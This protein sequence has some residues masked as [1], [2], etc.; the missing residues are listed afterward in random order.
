[1]LNHAE[2]FTLWAANPT[3]D[4][5][6]VTVNENGETVTSFCAAGS[7]S[8]NTVT[9]P[10]DSTDEASESYG[11]STGV[12]AGIAVACTVV[13]CVI[14]AGLAYWCLKRRRTAGAAVQEAATQPQYTQQQQDAMTQG[15]YKPELHGPPRCELETHA[16]LYVE[17]PTVSGSRFELVG[18][19]KSRNNIMIMSRIW[20]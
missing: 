10:G 7:G 19:A 9:T 17:H 3:A 6:L 11:L 16:G 20:P 4:E 15:Y 2:E 14:A 13:A 18:D 5:D 1:M 8:N 12:T